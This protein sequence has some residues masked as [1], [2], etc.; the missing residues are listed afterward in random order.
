MVRG[1]PENPMAQIWTWV[2]FF[3]S[4]GDWQ[5]LKVCHGRTSAGFPARTCCN[6]SFLGP[7]RK[8]CGLG[9]LLFG[10]YRAELPTPGLVGRFPSV[11]LCSA[12]LLCF[13][14]CAQLRLGLPCALCPALPCSTWFA[15]R[16]RFS[17]K[18]NRE[19]RLI[20]GGSGVFV[21]P[22]YFGPR[23]QDRAKLPLLRQKLQGPR[24]SHGN[25]SIKS[26]RGTPTKRPRGEKIS[27]PNAQSWR[28]WMA[29]T[30]TQ[31]AHLLRTLGRAN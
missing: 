10:C 2:C 24:C 21:C 26:A 20:S 3:L 31:T 7:D 17:V 18:N 22:P 30:G 1:C 4:R 6:E 19:R 8:V 15:S 11:L 13:P 27:A 9:S 14:W 29:Q 25:D 12:L 23:E 16:S 28:A 5:L